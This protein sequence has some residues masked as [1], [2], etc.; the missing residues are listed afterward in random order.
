MADISHRDYVLPLQ[1]YIKKSTGNIYSTNGIRIA[2]C[3]AL[4]NTGIDNQSSVSP[5]RPYDTTEILAHLWIPEEMK[6]L[7]R[8]AR[9]TGYGPVLTCD[10][11]N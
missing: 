2:G 8:T 1:S 9:V 6:L 5:W 4:A 11:A 10:Y 3:S 7:R